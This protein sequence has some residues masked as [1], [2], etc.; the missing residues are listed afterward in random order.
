ML[1]SARCHRSPYGPAGGDP[2][3]PGSQS[4]GSG[5]EYRHEQPWHHEGPG[6]LPSLVR[7]VILRIDRLRKVIGQFLG[8]DEPPHRLA[9]RPRQ[10]LEGLILR[11]PQN[12]RAEP[13]ACLRGTDDLP[14]PADGF[15]DPGQLN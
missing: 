11:I 9:D 7:G 8:R 5:L 4:I 3:W 15:D 14:S 10:P 2:S 1:P 13:P 12:I 6:P